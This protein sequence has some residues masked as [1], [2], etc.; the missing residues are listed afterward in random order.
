MADSR[1]HF[2][3]YGTLKPGYRGF[4]QFCQAHNPHIQPAQTS[5]R[6][7]H[8]PQAGYPAM[9]KE[10]GRVRGILL[11]FENVPGLMA[12]LD[13]YEGYNPQA[14]PDQNHYQR[15]W[16]RVW[17]LSGAD[18][19]G[20]WVYVMGLERVKREHGQWLPNGEWPKI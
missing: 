1:Q 11:I 10:S 8:L 19:G 17:S 5:G 9:T 3:V 18:L 14:A 2:F 20:A 7:Y 12:T 4:H 15:I 16:Q 6:I 13:D